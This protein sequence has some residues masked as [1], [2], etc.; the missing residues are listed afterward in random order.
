M[1]KHWLPAVRPKTLSMAIAP[2]LVGTTLAWFEQQQFSLLPL[3]LT[4]AAALLIQIGTNLYND[5]ADFERGAD[6]AGRLGPARVVAEGLIPATRVRHGAWLS[7]ALALL[8]GIYLVWLGGWPILLIGLF[9]L[10]AAYAYTGGAHPIAYGPFGELFVLVFFGVIA[11]AGSAYLQTG[12]WS[13][14]AV[15]AGMAIGM[16][17][18]AALLVNNYRDLE[19]DCAAGRRTL[20]SLL[21]R[22]LARRLYAIYILTP[23]TLVPLLIPAER[24]FLPW[25]VLPPA[26]VLVRR[27]WCSP[28]D[29]GLN[30]LLALTAQYQLLFAVLLISAW[31]F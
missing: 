8:C 18:A 6:T 28:I 16:P 21:G 24:V 29:T 19:S 1:F 23:L 27:F 22:R 10:A 11:V 17:A 26:I 4:L 5:A 30:R 25:L 12:I 3:L 14:A 7:F 2:V 20:V 15:V 9:S 31:L 13:A